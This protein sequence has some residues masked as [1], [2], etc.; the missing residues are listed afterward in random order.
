MSSRRWAAHAG[1]AQPP[2]RALRTAGA[3]V[4]QERRV[5]C[6][7]DRSVEAASRVFA[8]ACSSWSGRR[9]ARWES[10]RSA[11]GRAG[12]G[13]GGGG[14]CW[15][16]SIVARRT[17]FARSWRSATS[18]SRS[19]AARKWRWSRA[20]FA[21]YSSLAKAGL[22]AAGGL[23]AGC[24]AR[25]CRWRSSW[26]RSPRS[27]RAFCSTRSR[28]C[29]ARRTCRR[30]RTNATAAILRLLDELSSLATATHRA[31]HGHRDITGAIADRSTMRSGRC[32][33]WS[34]RSTAPQSSSM[35][36]RA[37]RRRSPRIS[38]RR[39]PRSRTRSPRHPSRSR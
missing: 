4:E 36:R 26:S 39:R 27:A 16:P 35:R 13:D 38:R 8:T 19:Q 10:N 1:I 12:A 32:G 24:R 20:A 31:G 2:A 18:S 14:G 3:A 34:P 7:R 15:Q 22:P 17:R 23:S 28:R 5:A 29:A 30:G 37:R 6:R 11:S 25:G 9:R 33:N 21:A